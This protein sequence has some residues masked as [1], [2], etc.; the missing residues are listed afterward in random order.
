MQV[1]IHFMLEL[2][3]SS[4][5]TFAAKTAIAKA[6]EEQTPMVLDRIR[7]QL[8]AFTKQ[9]MASLI[10]RAVHNVVEERVRETLDKELSVSVIRDAARLAVRNATIEAAARSK[11]RLKK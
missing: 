11:A 8:D 9:V 6:I 1:P 7:G 10:E 5:V 4:D 3:F 2:D